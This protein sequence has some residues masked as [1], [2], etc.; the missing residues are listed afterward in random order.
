MTIL[1]PLWARAVDAAPPSPTM[2]ARDKRNRRLDWFIRRVIE[3][4][5]TI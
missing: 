2:I 3:V 5:T 1:S 4:W